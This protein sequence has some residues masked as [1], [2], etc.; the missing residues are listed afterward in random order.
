MKLKSLFVAF[1]PVV[2]SRNC[3]CKDRNALDIYK[4]TKKDP[5]VEIEGHKRLTVLNSCS[6]DISTGMTGSDEDPSYGSQCPKFQKDNGNGRCFWSLDTPDVLK[7]GE[8]WSVDMTSETDHVISGNIY[9]T[10][11]EYMKDSCPSGRCHSWVGPMGAISRAEFTISRE[12]VDYFDISIIEGANL[13]VQMYPNDRE[14]DPE[15]RYMCGTAG[16]GSWDFKPGDDLAK[17]VTMVKNPTNECEISTDCDSSLVC[18]ASF[19]TSPPIYG[20]CGEFHGIASAHLNCVAGSTGPPFFCEA[21]H[22]VLS[23]MGE[24]SLSGYNSPP[25][26]TVC[27]CSKWEKDYDIPAPPIAPCITSD[28]YWEEKSLPFLLFLKTACPLCYTYAYDD[29]SSTVTCGDSKSYTIEF[30]PGDTES[31]F[32][33]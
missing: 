28:K 1:L 21:N 5:N 12:G 25:G 20:L 18:G 2:Y 11:V 26:S 16:S 33:S 24:Y 27:G 15:D 13:P 9:A 22:D 4:E 3:V 29:F 14:V 31:S 10:K 19:E 32:F 23:C 7:S 17:F 8:E 6:F 30:C